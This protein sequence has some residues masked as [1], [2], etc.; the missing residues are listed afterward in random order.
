VLR[1]LYARLIAGRARAGIQFPRCPA[2]CGEAYVK[3]QSQE[4]WK[5]I[6]ARYGDG[7]SRPRSFATS[8]EIAILRRHLMLR[9]IRYH[10]REMPLGPRRIHY[11]FSVRFLS[12]RSRL[13]RE[14]RAAVYFRLGDGH[15]TP[16]ARF[17]GWPRLR[18]RPPDGQLF[19]RTGLERVARRPRS[20]VRNHVW[21]RALYPNFW[22]SGS[23]PIAEIREFPRCS[24]I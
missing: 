9:K 24:L 23:V 14:I 20:Q 6:R 15:A 16:T 19:R 10:S 11:F 7:P 1:R 4:G 12:A 18:N 5:L 2:R 21:I 13:V 8:L 22:G 3:S 17:W